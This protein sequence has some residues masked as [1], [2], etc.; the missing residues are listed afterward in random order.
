M[1][2]L[3]NIIGVSFPSNKRTNQ[4][5]A[6]KF[7]EWNAKKISEKIG[8][9]SR[10][11][12]NEEEDSYSLAENALDDLY[13]KINFDLKID[14]LL[15]VSNSSKKIAPGDGHLLLDKIRQKVKPGCIDINLGCSGY[16][17]ALGLAQSLIISRAASKILIITTDQYSKY[18]GEDDKGNMAI[19][20]DAATASIVT[21]DKFINSWQISNFY[22]GASSEGYNSLNINY[23]KEF[24]MNGHDI[25]QFTSKDV[26]SFI[27]NQKLDLNDHKVIFHQANKF[28]LGY[29]RKKLN[30]HSDNFIIDMSQTGNTVSSSIPVAMSQ[31]INLISK[32]KLFLCGFGIGSSFSSV[33]LTL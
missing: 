27:K 22:Y 32:Y 5:I 14:I 9:Q 21:K 18:I 29:M 8:I 12:C 20:G 25:F 31:N 23:K 4:N 13:S 1:A 6:D 15:F 11:I 26:V 10:N 33:V 24:F 30:I 3:N 28:M 7:P 16:T 2:F 17:Y 19:F